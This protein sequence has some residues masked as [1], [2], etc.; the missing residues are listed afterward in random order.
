[1]KDTRICA[2]VPTY[3]DLRRALRCVTTLICADEG[4]ASVLIEW[5]VQD[6]SEQPEL[7]G[8][9]LLENIGVHYAANETRL[10]FA[11]N[12][13][14]AVNRALNAF[15]DTDILL[16]LNQDIYAHPERTQQW[17]FN[18]IDAFVRYPE[19]QVIGGLLLFPDNRVQHAGIIFDAL[20]Q[21]THRYLGYNNADWPKIMTPTPIP[22]VTGAAI[23]VRA[24]AWIEQ[25][26]F[27]HRTYPFGY[28]EDIDFCCGIRHTY[29]DAA[30]MY[31]PS[32]C[33]YHEGGTTGGNPNFAK[34]AEAFRER[35][36]GSVQTRPSI[37]AI[38]EKFWN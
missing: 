4:L 3:N 7:V 13:N 31:V 34:N 1:M 23:A 17:V 14:T 10:G 11:E 35:W 6:D 32:V 12:C 33:F 24:Q 29:G 21:P 8:L 25:G 16:I 20:R 27:D 37:N 28:F 2:I 19:S 5:F 22:A 36:A 9:P 38:V 15:P 30:V 18:L 26:G